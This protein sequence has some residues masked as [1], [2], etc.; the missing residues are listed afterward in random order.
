MATKKEKRARALAKHEAYI[1]AW[2]Q[3]G[4]DALQKDR[5]RRAREHQNALELAIEQ[6]KKVSRM[7]GAGRVGNASKHS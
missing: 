6:N 4:L 5:D 3:E 2:R 7:T 1:A